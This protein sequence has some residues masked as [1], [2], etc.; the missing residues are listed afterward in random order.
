LT[1]LHESGLAPE[2]VSALFSSYRKFTKI[3]TK[4]FV[5]EDIVEQIT[6]T[7]WEAGELIESRIYR[8]SFESEYF[9][10]N[11]FITIANSENGRE[12]ELPI[13]YSPSFLNNSREGWARDGVSE[14]FDQVTIIDNN[15]GIDTVNLHQETLT[16]SIP[17]RFSPYYD[18]RVT[19]QEE[20]VQNTA[21]EITGVLLVPSDGK[22][23]YTSDKD[24]FKSG[25]AKT[26]GLY[27]YYDS[28]SDSFYE[29]VY[30]LAPDLD[31]DGVYEVMSI[32]YNSDN[33]HDFA[34]YEK[35]TIDEPVINRDDY[36]QHI[37]TETAQYGNWVYD[38]ARLEERVETLFPKEIYDGYEPKDDLFEIWKL[39]KKSDQ[40]YKFSQLFYEV[41]HKEYDK[42]SN[43]YYKNFERDIGEQVFA[44][45]VASGVSMA[46]TA[47]SLGTATLLAHAAYIVIYATIRKFQM[48][49]KARE[50]EAMERSTSFLPEGIDRN[51]PTSLNQKIT[52]DEFW[53]DSMPAALSGHPGAYYTTVM[54]GEVG[55]Q[56]T[57]QAIVSPPNDARFWN[58]ENGM[59]GYLE[60]NLFT[61]G[62]GDP[63]LFTELDFDNHNLDYLLVS[64]ELYAYNDEEHVIY[65]EDPSLVE[66]L[67]NPEIIQKQFGT[68]ITAEIYVLSVISTRDSYA[69]R[70]NTL[71]YIT[72]EV[73]QASNGSLTTIKA[74]S[75]DGQ[76]RY[77]FTTEDDVVPE[78]TLFKPLIVSPDRYEELEN[79][80]L[81]DGYIVID[82]QASDST[83]AQGIDSSEMTI[84][85]KG[86]YSAKIPLAD[87]FGGFNYPIKSVIAYEMN[88]DRS[89]N[90]HLL[91]TS[92]YT[93]DVGNL[94]FHESLEELVSTPDNYLKFVIQIAKIIPDDGSEEIKRD[95]L[96]I[97]TTYAIMDYFDQYTFA[98]TSAQ[99][100]AEIGYTEIMT[101][102]SMAISA[103]FI[104]LG[105]YAVGAYIEASAIASTAAQKLIADT[106]QKSLVKTMVS[107]F[108][109]K[110][111]LYQVGKQ[112]V[113]GTIKETIEEIV[114]DG[115]FE[116]A[117]QSAV[118][119]VGGPND[120]GHWIS[121]LFTSARESMN[122][123]SLTGIG[124]QSQQQTFAGQVQTAMGQDVEFL[125]SVMD[126]KLQYEDDVSIAQVATANEQFLTAKMN[127]F[128]VLESSIQESKISVG[129]LLATGIFT[130]LAMLTPSL[131]GFNLYGASKLIGGVGSKIDAKIQ[132]MF[133]AAR[134]S[135]ML[136]KSAENLKKQEVELGKKHID[137][138]LDGIKRENTPRVSNIPD[139]SSTLL[140]SIP[141]ETSVVIGGGYSNFMSKFGFSGGRPI[142]SQQIIQEAI[143][144][145]IR[146]KGLLIT[147]SLRQVEAL[148]G[149]IVA[150]GDLGQTLLAIRAEDKLNT[151]EFGEIVNI[152]TK[153]Y[154]AIHTGKDLSEI[155]G[156]YDASAYHILGYI[157]RKFDNKEM[158]NTFEEDVLDLIIDIM[159]SAQA[160]SKNIYSG[161]FSRQTWEKTMKSQEIP[162]GV[163]PFY[164]MFLSKVAKTLYRNGV[165]STDPDTNLLGSVQ[166]FTLAIGRSK[167]NLWNRISSMNRA[168]LFGATEDLLYEIYVN[169]ENLISTRL[170]SSVSYSAIS[171]LRQDFDF[172][173]FIQGDMS[174]NFFYEEARLLIYKINDIISGASAIPNYDGT[175]A[176]LNDVLISF[177]VVKFYIN[178]KDAKLPPSLRL[179][180][181]LRT[182]IVNNLGPYITSAQLDKILYLVDNFKILLLSFHNGI[183]LLE[184]YEDSYRKALIND[185]INS[186]FTPI[187]E[188]CSSPNSLSDL[189]F[190]N[191]YD[192]NNNF[193][194]DIYSRPHLHILQHIKL[195]VLLW[196][197]DDFKSEG[198][199]D[200]ATLDLLRE[201]IISKINK[202]ISGQKIFEYYE[203]GRGSYSEAVNYLT[204]GYISSG[205]EKD[206][207]VYNAFHRA[208]TAFT[209]DSKMSRNILGHMIGSSGLFQAS[210]GHHFSIKI[211]RKMVSFLEMLIRD[212]LSPYYIPIGHYDF[213]GRL[214]LIQRQSIYKE[215]LDAIQEHMAE[216]GIDRPKNWL[217]ENVIAYHVIKG[218]KRNIGMDFLSFTTLDKNIFIKTAE[219]IL[220]FARHHF[221]NDFFRKLSNYIQDQ[222]LTS[223]FYHNKYKSYSEAE[224]L[225]IINGFDKM[226][227]MKGSG[228]AGA[229]TKSDVINIFTGNEWVLYGPDGKGGKDG[230]TGWF[231]SKKGFDKMLIEF[232]IRK[233]LLQKEGLIQFLEKKYDTVYERF[234]L[235]FPHGSGIS[236]A[237]ADG[238]YSLV[239]P[240]PTLGDFGVFMNFD[241][242]L[243]Y[244]EY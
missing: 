54:G 175:L 162:S 192:L 157:S 195:R 38:F 102:T 130:G 71:G 173:T 244:P 144:E 73:R 104:A 79:Q 168:D 16:I 180:A 86:L 5:Q 200:K 151:R 81:V 26:S 163:A 216:F 49:M 225:V 24:A 88:G 12:T 115:F 56:Y 83:V 146:A 48:D 205:Y 11:E 201:E 103:P 177:E 223:N 137:P 190:G 95:A 23:Y 110:P 22:V 18:H 125:A 129:R 172:I 140:E 78:S 119:M 116:T 44:T 59:L 40:N 117:I 124:T 185:L 143:N 231:F 63:D 25:D 169:L 15:Q 8:D 65:V 128:G 138:Q 45:L 121:T 193:F 210:E 14:R 66:I 147:E 89:I 226:M 166:E 69:F 142:T 178:L 94:Y 29:T 238:F 181:N 70:Q 52:K 50:A 174:N 234:Y 37:S 160:S 211:F 113:I 21:F 111:L 13:G 141:V 156:I 232:N 51:E 84:T 35:I 109:L 91:T 62:H 131:A 108:A 99:M 101:V 122:F 112:V 150:Q 43:D 197:T 60:N 46:I 123:A 145:E 17:S 133:L 219:K 184:S 136:L 149:G 183:D 186:K 53:G 20:A 31:N 148:G 204:N 97:A 171:D 159:K 1:L 105:S 72:K 118:R 68:M 75:V 241:A 126:L 100:I 64:S 176:S 19:S 203:K 55:T 42:T 153:Y 61:L 188:Q 32:G 233:S 242:G 240:Q 209:G 41:R 154:E 212:D 87:T 206:L 170:S 182:S 155:K 58:K 132:N 208:V 230:K 27:F 207:V 33:E 218:L 127:E 237:D 189:L 217:D 106:A 57:A 198:H 3:S 74:T 76:P 135:K 28:D 187:L 36:K 199:I 34:P 77:V 221:R 96:N 152:L 161:L 220:N 222:I 215:S 9:D 6:V 235:N 196:T 10:S 114:V 243:L 214:T 236:I 90:S 30:V 85:E 158:L 120:M 98:Q 194:R 92:D 2:I 164:K 80:G 179:V 228:I 139:T 213:M 93:L 227:E 82:V 167:N 47:I 67:L 229:I 165:I 7:E 202:F 239:V 224:I 134:N 4:S 191:R 39:V 107:Q